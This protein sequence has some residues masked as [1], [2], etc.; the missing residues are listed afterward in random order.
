MLDHL[1]GPVL[2]A[3]IGLF[4]RYIV[5]ISIGWYFAGAVQD[6]MVLF[7]STRR[8]GNSLGEMM[9]K[10]MGPVPGTIALFVAVSIMII[11]LGG[12]SSDCSESISRKSLGSLHRLF[13]STLLPRH[14]WGSHCAIFAQV[15]GEVS[16]IGSCFTD[17]RYLVW[18]R[19]RE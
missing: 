5:V 17:C 15:V 12:A 6:F 3:Q 19:Y 7:I 13:N 8:N 2:A 1:V 16:V 14:L 9:A 10:E 18:W 11:I 4:T